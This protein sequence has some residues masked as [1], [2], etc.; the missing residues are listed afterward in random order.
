MTF[1][2]KGFNREQGVVFLKTKALLAGNAHNKGP[3]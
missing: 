3:I 1:G 2:L